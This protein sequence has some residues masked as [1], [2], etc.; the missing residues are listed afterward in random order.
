MFDTIVCANPG[1]TERLRNGGV[2]GVET[3]PLGVEAGRFSPRLRSPALRGTML[4]SLDLPN[5]AILL[6][7]LGRLSAEKQWDV[8]IR[9][10]TAAARDRPLGLVLIGDGPQRSRLERLAQRSRHVQ[11]HHPIADRARLAV[12]LASADALVHGCSAETFCLAG[13]E[14][15]ASGI[16]LIVPDEGA[17]AGH[18]LP[19]AGTQYR[20]GDE[21]ALTAAIG[22]FAGRG[23]EL[24]RVA[25][26]RGSRVRTV[27]E[28][29]AELFARYTALSDDNRS[30]M[31]DVLQVPL[32][33]SPQLRARS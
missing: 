9:A 24:Q 31:T 19:A 1:L 26:C 2:T 3:I 20:A 10:V 4:R 8:V 12:L 32:A 25:A 28:H 21:G 6:V 30:S 15:R 7:A 13:A 11:V 22:R 17:A 23:I 18:F 5:D 16:P 29:F 33:R 27:D 14:A